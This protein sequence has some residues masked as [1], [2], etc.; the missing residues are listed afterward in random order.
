MICAIYCYQQQPQQLPSKM[1][2]VP[3]AI[4]PIKNSVGGAAQVRPVLKNA[5]KFTKKK[6]GYDT[7]STNICTK[8]KHV[9]Q[10]VV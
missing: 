2:C 7:G 6:E 9:I 8:I 5:R 4:I 1:V 10:V 3:P